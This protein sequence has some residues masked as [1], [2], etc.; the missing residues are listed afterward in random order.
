[1]QSIRVIFDEAHSEAWTIRPQLAEQMQ[2]VHPAD[3]SYAHAAELLAARA[4]RV[5]ANTEPLDG[6]VLDSCD[7]LVIAHPSE[8]TWESTTGIGSP[9]LTPAEQDAIH[10]FVRDGGGLIVLGET[11]QDKYG[12]NVN[13]LLGRFDLRLRSD[14]VQDYEHCD[15]PPTWIHAE[16]VDGGRGSGGDLLAGVNAACF[17]RATTIES[18]NGARVPART[19]RSASIPGAPLIVATEHGA[20]RVVVLGDS[21]LFGD[22]CIGTLDHAAL[23]LNI[24]GWAARRP[25]DP[26]SRCTAEVA[27]GGPS[28]RLLADVR[29]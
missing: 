15:G 17:Y 27:A 26:P 2:P 22:D 20:G 8:P 24:V 16:L 1:M 3:A 18:R 19:Y 12:N 4:F 25:A 5:T 10:A 29:R 23:W 13:D 14:T 9:K 21:D 28:D 11:E 7:L 6:G